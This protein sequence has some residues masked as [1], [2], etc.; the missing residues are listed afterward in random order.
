MPRQEPLRAEQRLLVVVTHM[1]QL[2]LVAV[3]S[4]WLGDIV[5]GLVGT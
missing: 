3:S 4:W 1:W 2:F 5:A